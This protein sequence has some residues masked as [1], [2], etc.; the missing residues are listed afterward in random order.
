[1]RKN[2]TYACNRV[3][4]SNGVDLNP[5]LDVIFIMLVFF[6]VVAS[7]IKEAGVPEYS[8]EGQSLQTDSSPSLDIYIDHANAIEVDG[9][10]VS[11]AAVRSLVAQKLAAFD[12]ELAVSIRA[13]SRAHVERYVSVVDA[14][15]RTHAQNI[16]FT[17]LEESMSL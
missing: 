4:E 17:M 3:D 1:M 2:K 5:M 14:V 10:R 13:D 12:S 16:S 8:R 7:F 11:I 15:Q 9:R 6:I